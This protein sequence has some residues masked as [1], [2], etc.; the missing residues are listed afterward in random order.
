MLNGARVKITVDIAEAVDTVGISSPAMPEPIALLLLSRHIDSLAKGY[1]LSE[2]PDV[3]A[4]PLVAA[5]RGLPNPAVDLIGHFLPEAGA[6][7]ADDIRRRLY[8]VF[9]DLSRETRVLGLVDDVLKL[10]QIYWNL[11]GTED[12]PRLPIRAGQQLRIGG[13]T[14]QADIKVPGANKDF[15]NMKWVDRCKQQGAYTSSSGGLR[16]QGARLAVLAAKQIIDA[17][18]EAPASLED[19]AIRRAENENGGSAV[20]IVWPDTT[21]PSTAEHRS[22]NDRDQAQDSVPAITSRARAYLAIDELR[23]RPA[24][25]DRTLP[26]RSPSAQRMSLALSSTVS[27]GDRQAPMSSRPAVWLSTCIR[28]RPTTY[29]GEIPRL[30]QPN[31]QT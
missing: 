9:V 1:G 28:R 20:S 16:K 29:C 6:A 4:D 13:T 14:T 8:S 31:L 26:A 30:Y 21:S 19:V 18:P 22:V 25:V 11:T 10:G 12:R 7:N 23:A 27:P 24:T 3:T 15:A 2:H 17:T 5:L